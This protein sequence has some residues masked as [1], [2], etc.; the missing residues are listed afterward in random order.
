M[1][2]AVYRHQHGVFY[3]AGCPPCAVWFHRA[4]GVA[5]L[6]VFAAVTLFLG[7][8]KVL[9]LHTGRLPPEPINRAEIYIDGLDGPRL[10]LG[11]PPGL[12]GLYQHPP[13]PAAKV[14]PVERP[15][16]IGPPAPHDPA[17]LTPKENN[18][19]R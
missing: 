10:A 2:A 16:D 8:G 7:F 11:R 17:T 12:S 4:S 13:H 1:T 9:A 5:A 15:A 19:D 14:E 18:H 6:A 3:R